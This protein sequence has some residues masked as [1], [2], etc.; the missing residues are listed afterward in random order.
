MP[1][2]P[3]RFFCSLLKGVVCFFLLVLAK[4]VE[5][6]L[7]GVGTIGSPGPGNACTMLNRDAMPPF[8]EKREKARRT[9]AL[10]H[11]IGTKQPHLLL[12]KP[13][14][15]IANPIHGTPLPPLP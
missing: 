12:P 5:V 14:I 3:L 11:F 4:R 6:V 8:R 7:I 2:V 15:H 10:R 9:N 13:N 1:L